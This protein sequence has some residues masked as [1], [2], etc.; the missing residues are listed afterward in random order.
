[1]Y[2]DDNLEK[3]YYFNED[4]EIISHKK[5]RLH[6][7]NP[8]THKKSG[9]KPRIP[10]VVEVPVKYWEK[11]KLG[12][13]NV[14]GGSGEYWNKIAQKSEARFKSKIKPLPDYDTTF[15]GWRERLGVGE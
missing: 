3:P 1:M 10:K 14:L 11:S 2:Y 15:D 13:R 9:R 8:M 12:S 4:N 7:T 6:A 5:D